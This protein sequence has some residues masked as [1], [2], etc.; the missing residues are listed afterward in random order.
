[1]RSAYRERLRLPCLGLVLTGVVPLLTG[2][3]ASSPARADVRT[4]AQLEWGRQDVPPAWPARDW[5]R[6]FGSDELDGM[7]DR[8]VEANLDLQ[9]ATQRVVQADAR[10]RQAHAAILPSVGIDG[11]DNYLAGHSSNGSYHETDWSALLSASYEI[12]FWGKNRAKANAAGFERLAT[13]ADHDTVLLTTEA[14]VADTYLEVISLRERLV[15]AR[16]NVDS[17]RQLLAIVQSRFKAGYAAPVDVAN[18][19]G[20]LA[21]LATT[22]PQLEQSETQSLT[23]LALLLGQPPEHFAVRAQ[24]LAALREPAVAPGLPAEL[25]RRRPDVARAEASL[26]AAHAD[27]Q[28]TRAALY[29]SITLTAAGGVANP[30]VNAAVNTLAGVGPT[31]NLGAS[32]AQVVFDGGRLRAQR[33][34]AAG[35]EQE[36]LAGYRASVLAALVDVENSLAAIARLDAAQNDQQQL[37]EQSERAYEG[38]RLRYQ[39][40]YGDFL[41]VLEAQRAVFAARDQFDQYRLARLQARVSLCKALGGGW[42]GGDID[43]RSALTVTSSGKSP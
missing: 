20:A 3:P 11:S 1:M 28:A 43:S 25:L 19:G 31:L 2:C 5:F 23:A 26:A 36:L 35:H 13:R 6:G 41:S 37:L 4:P 22:I 9:A 15:T 42:Q 21:S 8:A 24:S 38:A 16:A 27:L 14:G 40:G 18:Q 30:A 33:D 32:L 12:D 7:I 17:A 10:A 29:P 34:E 39:K